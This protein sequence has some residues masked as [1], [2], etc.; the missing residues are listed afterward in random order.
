MDNASISSKLYSIREVDSKKVLFES[1]SKIKADFVGVALALASL[2]NGRETYQLRYGD[3]SM[4]TYESETA[5]GMMQG[6]MRNLIYNRR[7]TSSM[8]VV[9]VDRF[10][11]MAHSRVVKLIK[12]ED[13]KEKIRKKVEKATDRY[14][15]HVE[16]NL[17]E[18]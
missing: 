9:P 13:G 3:I 11:D 7:V 1:E 5:F 6:R 8:P 12:T 2:Y 10:A 16:D 4:L 18:S 15:K 17:A 14:I